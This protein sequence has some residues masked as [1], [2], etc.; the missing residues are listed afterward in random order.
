MTYLSI[1]VPMY[2][3]QANVIPMYT[4]LTKV[5]QKLDKSYE[6]MFVD[7]GSRDKTLHY[8]S[9]LNSRD[10]R[11]KVISF[12][13][14]FGKAAGLAAG[15]DFANGEIV[16][17]MDGDL[18]DEPAEIPKFL[19]VMN[20]GYDLVSGWKQTKHK[21]TL[22]VLPS[23]IFNHLTRRIT[24]FKIHDNN[25]TFKAYILFKECFKNTIM[26]SIS[27]SQ[28]HSLYNE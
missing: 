16:I 10:K 5:L 23:K 22:R 4:K 8:L 2:N 21:G 1:I 20:K 18:Q 28:A 9:E 24:V 12:R 15:F 11:V 27:S 19:Y 6:I 25:F 26:L 7:D 17:T 3:E 14:N 13:K